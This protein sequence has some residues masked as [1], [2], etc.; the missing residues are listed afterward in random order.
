MPSTREAILASSKNIS[1]KSPM[2]KKSSA[3]GCSFLTPRYCSI[4]G[5]SRST[6]A[7]S[8]SL[9][10]MVRAVSSGSGA[11]ASNAPARGAGGPPIM[12]R[13]RP[14]VKDLQRLTSLHHLQLLAQLDLVGKQR[15][16]V[17]QERHC[18]IFLADAHVQARELEI[19]VRVARILV[20][21]A[22][23]GEQRLELANGF[24]R[25]ALGLRVVAQVGRLVGARLPEPGVELDRSVVLGEHEVAEC[26]HARRRRLGH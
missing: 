10:I 13:P 4:I 25:L 5:V 1:K 26:F 12:S 21:A 16:T 24:R 11:C 6:G 8:A 9:S 14:C 23:L 2:R 3:S 19:G 15:K 17:A 22:L 20:R 7:G 18:L